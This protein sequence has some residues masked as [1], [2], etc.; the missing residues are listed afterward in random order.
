VSEGEKEYGWEKHDLDASKGPSPR[1]AHT[2]TFIGKGKILVFGGQLYR[3]RQMIT[4]F[5]MH[6]CM[7]ISL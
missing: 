4:L 7:F 2:A 1:E 3:Y 6:L 5:S